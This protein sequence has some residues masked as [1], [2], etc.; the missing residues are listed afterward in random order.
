M[1]RSRSDRDES[2][3]PRPL[4]DVDADGAVQLV[5]SPDPAPTGGGPGVV[6]AIW[7]GVFA[8]YVVLAAALLG[9]DWLPVQDQAVLD[10]RVR[11][12][13]AGSDVPLVGAFS[14]FGWSHPGPVWFYVLAPFRTI[15][16]PNGVLVGSILLFGAGVATAVG[17]VVRRYGPIVGAVAGIALVPAIAASGSFTLIVPWNPHLAVAWYPAFLVLCISAADRRA[18]DLAP[19]A[20]LAAALVQLHVGY[21]VLAALPLLAASIAT[22]I[23]ERRRLG[24]LARS[25]VMRPTS[26]AWLAA[27]VVLWLPPLLEQARNG[28]DG[29]LVALQRFFLHGGG[30]E[31][32]AGMRFAAG[33]LGGVLR[34]PL[35]GV[36]G[37][38]EAREAFTGYLIAG[39]PWSFVAIA[40]ALALTVV[41][42]S[43]RRDG[44]GIRVVAV[45]GVTAASGLLAL[46]RLLGERWPYLF[47]WRFVLVWCVLAGC[48]VVVARGSAVG[49]RAR[50]MPLGPQRML[51]AGAVALL[52]ATTLLT[53]WGKPAE[54]FSGQEAQARAMLDAVERTT[55]PRGDVTVV[56][57]GGYLIGVAD[58][59]LDRLDELGWPV[60]VPSDLGYKYGDARSLDPERADRF[61]L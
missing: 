56:R 36:G 37:R 3:D 28:S 14:R 6:A 55:E 21:V 52:A 42:A 13:L 60:R 61:G 50:R 41:V 29:N 40:V 45:L 46:S 12:V 2:D 20:F 58:A 22:L 38:G 51:A 32:P 44:R 26:W 19:A 11:D 9:S 18:R 54:Q 17:L 24:A 5:A 59:V 35:T 49:E 27:V 39:S 10:M 7:V 30:G 25:A 1:I 31:V 4:S 53:A 15:G 47:V 23:R 34:L 48:A 33:A 8:P 43:V 16:G 57:F